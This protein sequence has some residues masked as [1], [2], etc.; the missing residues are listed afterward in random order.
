[1]LS[2][3]ILFAAT[4]SALALP[5]LEVNLEALLNTPITIIR[6]DPSD[7]T[8][9][10]HKYSQQPIHASDDDDDDDD[11]PLPVILWHGLGDASNADGLR[12]TA[13][14]LEE[15]HPGTYV[16]LISATTS[17]SDRSASFFGNVTEQIDLVCE[18]LQRDP[19]L[20]TAP[21][22]DAVGFS[23]GG[24]FLRGYIERC[25]NP[26]VRS[27][28]TFGS[29]HNGIS[30]FEKCKSATDLVCHAANALLKSSTVWSHYVQS[31]VVPAQYYR[32]SEDY[33]N[34][35]NY[36]NFLADI[37]N[38]RP[39]KNATYKKNLASLRNFVM[40][41]FE[42]DAT[43]IPK[44]SGWFSQVNM[45]SGEVVGVRNRT[46]YEED[47]IGLKKLDEGGNLKFEKVRGEHMQLRE[48]DLKR[49]FGEYFGPLGGKD[50]GRKVEKVNKVYGVEEMKS[51]L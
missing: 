38:E 4:A 17:P 15:T 36:S 18:T 45:T 23:Q 31:H 30:A 1:M 10:T 22:V 7:S 3:I 44:E 14:L 8:I 16:H 35:L 40:V 13:S 41:M 51:D 42:D 48:K 12:D 37:N 39:V 25:N 24:Q 46:I 9:S 27:L 6:D 19:I 2:N 33:E 28:I 43:V 26:P 49:L 11:S 34:Y 50:A 29:Q 20:S 5:P 21:A 32:D 47:W